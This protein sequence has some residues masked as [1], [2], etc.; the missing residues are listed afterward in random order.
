MRRLILGTLALLV[1]CAPG[2]GGQGH[3]NST[4]ND[5]AA[6]E[7]A[8]PLEHNR[9]TLSLPALGTLA[10]GAEFDAVLEGAFTEELFQGSGRLIYDSSVLQPVA[11]QRGAF[12]PAGDIFVARD[13]I[14]PGTLPGEGSLDGVIPFAF[15]GRPGESGIAPGS[16][17]L[18]RVRFK[19]LAPAAGATRLRL[20]NNAEYLQ[21]R[22]N[23][24][25]RLAFDLATEEVGQ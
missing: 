15:T 20:M 1:L 12:I 24:G 3:S 14:A 17:E 25:R 2:C 10:A 23:T 16:G 7:T 4:V 13:N 18:L 8:A 22:D 21:L 19:L 9:L 6:P 5:P 11:S